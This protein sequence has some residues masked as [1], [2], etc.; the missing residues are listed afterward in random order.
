VI[1]ENGIA[2]R[3]DKNRA[4]FLAEHLYQL[5]WAMQD[6]VDVR[7]YFH[8]SLMDNFEWQNGFC[9]NFGFASVDHTTAAR[10]LRASGNEFKSIVNSRVIRTSDIDAL[11]AYQATTYCE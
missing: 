2:D 8:W 7:G 1:T 5:G 9:P 6:G 4:R 11:P 10:T 3:D